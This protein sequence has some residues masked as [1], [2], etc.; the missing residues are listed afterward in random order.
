LR[1]LKQ[2][3]IQIEDIYK[4]SDQEVLRTLKAFNIDMPVGV[5]TNVARKILIK[6]YYETMKYVFPS[7]EREFIGSKN[8]DKLIRNGYTAGVQAYLTV[9]KKIPTDLADIFN[10]FNHQPFPFLASAPPL[11][12]IDNDDLFLEDET[13]RKLTIALKKTQ[14]IRPFI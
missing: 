7:N 10:A 1:Q 6:H 13:G 9:S 14:A 5:S 3:Q 12:F 2:P 11:A 8:F 4:V